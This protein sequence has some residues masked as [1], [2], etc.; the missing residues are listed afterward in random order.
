[1]SQSP[2]SYLIYTTGLLISIT[3][4]AIF[5]FTIYRFSKTTVNA[6]IETINC[7]SPQECSLNIVYYY[8][9]VKV[10]AVLYSKYNAWYVNQIIP[11]YIN[12]QDLTAPRYSPIMVS[13]ALYLI[14][15]LL[16]VFTLLFVFK[17]YK[18]YKNKSPYVP[19]P[20]QF[21]PQP[22]NATVPDSF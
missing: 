6:M 19:V 2:S 5:A 16:L 1:M 11:I 14:T 15:S 22:L 4:F 9:S 18:T 20:Q 17:I 21:A 12:P 13:V 8:N 3:L 7:R 10:N